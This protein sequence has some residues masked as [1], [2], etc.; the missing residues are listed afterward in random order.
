[1]YIHM[2]A[3]KSACMHPIIKRALCIYKVCVHINIG[4]VRI[5]QG[6]LPIRSR[7]VYVCS[8]T[9]CHRGVN[10]CTYTQLIHIHAYIYTTYTYSRLCGILSLPHRMPQR[11]QNAFSLSRT[12][13][14][15]GHRM[16]SL[17]PAQNATE[18]TECH[19]IC[20]TECHRGVHMYKLCI[21]M[22]AYVQ[23]VCAHT[24]RASL[25]WTDRMPQGC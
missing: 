4:Q 17:S 16:P 11:P 1:M 19:R 2:R 5:P 14:H 8:R 12:E 18:A 23:G 3:T 15:R 20:A 7:C 9:E 13:C 10:E 6:P 22:H 21:C 24:F 25:T